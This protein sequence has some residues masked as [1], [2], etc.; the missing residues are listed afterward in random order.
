MILYRFRIPD[1]WLGLSSRRTERNGGWLR[2]GCRRAFRGGGWRCRWVVLQGP[3]VG[4]RGRRVGALGRRAGGAVGRRAATMCGGD[5][6]IV[7]RSGV[8]APVAGVV[9]RDCSAHVSGGSAHLAGRGADESGERVDAWVRCSAVLAWRTA[10]A[11]RGADVRAAVRMCWAAAPM[12]R[13]AR[14]TCRAAE[15]GFRRAAP[16]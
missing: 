11:S 6:P 2:G 15:E 13:G 1:R 4:V 7:S 14:R 9:V 16:M 5:G 8:G 10:G 3:R 12:S